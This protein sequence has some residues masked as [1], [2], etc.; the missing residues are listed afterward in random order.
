MEYFYISFRSRGYIAFHCDD[1]SL[2]TNVN[3]FKPNGI[4]H[5]YHLDQSIS[6]L[7]DAGCYFSV[8]S[9]FHRTFCKQT[10]ETLIRCR[11]LAASD[12]VLHCL[13]MSHKKEARFIWVK[14][15][16]SFVRVCCLS[17]TSNPCQ[18]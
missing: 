18:F 11:F 4:S 15:V 6:V 3:P 16:R 12:L 5:C 13:P 1:V 2:L 9:N 7:R 10:V 8:C 17:G 14:P